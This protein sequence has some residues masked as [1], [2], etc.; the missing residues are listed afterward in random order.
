MELG[1]LEKLIMLFKTSFSSFLMIELLLLFVCI[2][3]FLIF[4]EKIQNRL[5]KIA[6]S[7]LTFFIFLV[8]IFLYQAD[9][10]FALKE[11]FKELLTCFYFPNV[12]FYVL[13][14]MISLSC[15]VA[16]IFSK[17]LPKYEKF[18]SYLFLILHLYLFTVFISR[19]Y[20]LQVSFTSSAKIYQ[21]DELFVLIQASQLVFM[22]FI[23][24]KLIL[25]L[26]KRTRQKLK[27]DAG[28]VI[29]ERK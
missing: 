17:K 28:S 5:V 18:F 21:H 3:L 7:A 1:W 25:F 4:N 12:I 20:Q 2:G 23:I 9:F 11:I 8:F 13:T 22:I 14:V 29:I 6:I 26:F 24:I 16:T 19:A 15:F 27:K 10:I